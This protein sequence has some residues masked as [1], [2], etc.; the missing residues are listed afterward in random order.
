M[1]S[2]FNPPAANHA[3]TLA[4]TYCYGPDLRGEGPSTG[5]PAL[6][7]QM[8]GDDAS[9]PAR[10]TLL[11]WDGSRA[12]PT[13]YSRRFSIDDLVRWALGSAGQLVVVTGGEPLDQQDRLVVLVNELAH[14]GRQVEIETNATLVPTPRLVA[15]THLFV[16]APRLSSYDDTDADAS[17]DERINPAAV[18][19]FVSSE[20]A[21]FTFAVAGEADLNEISALEDRFSLYPIWVTPAG[22]T[23][24]KLLSTMPWLADSILDR[25]WHLSSPLRMLFH[26]DRPPREPFPSA[27]RP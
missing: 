27:S 13:G 9:N 14:F 5:Q 22:S 26:G 1:T 10:D 6:F 7:I 25:G 12:D 23:P 20:Q 24:E 4:I 18:E 17:G 11:S 19:A 15:A 3:K 2:A 8:A 21:V 16:V